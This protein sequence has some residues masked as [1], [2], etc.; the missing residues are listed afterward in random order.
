MD[1]TSYA[2]S[3]VI[4]GQATALVSMSPFGLRAVLKS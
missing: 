2:V 4:L 1:G 3:T